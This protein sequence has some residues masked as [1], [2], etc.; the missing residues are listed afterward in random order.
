M[1]ILIVGD[2]ESKA[3]WDYYKPGMLDDI[4]LI[5]S[6]GDLNPRYLTFLVTL[7][8]APVYYIHGNHD[9]K[10]E[11]FPPEGCTCIDGD[12]V[13]FNGIRILGLGGSMRYLPDTQNQ[14]TEREMRSRIRKLWLKIRRHKGFDILLTH[15]PAKGI[16]D[17]EDL[18]HQGFGC[19][20]ELLDKY[21]PRFFIHGH[22]HMSYG[23][24]YKRI[25][26]Y[27]DTHIINGFEQYLFDYENP[28]LTE[29]SRIGT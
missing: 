6:C 16:N 8:R 13:E 19:F 1:K 21:Q 15:S 27:E 28:D 10:Y 9:G 2:H 11:L 26:Q 4:D 5:L 18:P 20:L 7:A 3:I 14:Y 12:L 24:Q 29:V 22:V 25:D 23:R 17:G